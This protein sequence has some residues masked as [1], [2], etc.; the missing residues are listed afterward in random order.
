MSKCIIGID[1]GAQGAVAQI[2]DGK[3]LALKPFPLLKDGSMDSDKLLDTLCGMMSHE[4]D[5]ESNT[6]VWIE[7]VHSIQGSSAASNFSFGRNVGELHAVLKILN[8][9]MNMVQPKVWQKEIWDGYELIKKS[10]KTGKTMVNDTKA[11]SISIAQDLYPD[12]DLRRT[13]RSRTP[14]D[15]MSDALLIAEYGRRVN[16]KC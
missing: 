5:L 10:S 8:V 4:C 1:P 9:N 3:V 6:E 15:G 16:K 2:V 7:D 13:K 11:M 14:N 12:V